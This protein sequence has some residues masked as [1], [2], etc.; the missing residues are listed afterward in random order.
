MPVVTLTTT[1]GPA[2]AQELP[3]AGVK[4]CS[5]IQGLMEAAPNQDLTIEVPHADAATIKIICAFHEEHK[6][7]EEVEH[8][9]EKKRPR[10]LTAWDKENLAPFNGMAVANL[11]KAVNFLSSQLM[12]NTVAV[13]VGQKMVIMDA[14][15]IQDYYGI[16]KAEFTEEEKA[17]V[18]ARYPNPFFT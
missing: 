13:Y 8:D 5:Y 2:Y 17:A 11:L 14:K 16:Q 6:N 18:K 7:D 3:A 9:W 15:Q 12:L 4:F 1:V 10:E